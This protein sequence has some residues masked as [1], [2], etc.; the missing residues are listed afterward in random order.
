M[1]RKPY[2]I[3]RPVA[4]DDCRP[5]PH[6]SVAQWIEHQSSELRVAGSSP[7]GR[8]K[9]L[10]VSWENQLSHCSLFLFRAALAAPAPPLPAFRQFLPHFTPACTVNCPARST[11]FHRE[12]LSIAV[13]HTSG[14]ISSDAQLANSRPGSQRRQGTKRRLGTLC[15][16][17]T[18]RHFLPPSRS[19][20]VSLRFCTV[21]PRPISHSNQDQ[22]RV[23]PA[24]G[25]VAGSRKEFKVAHGQQ[26]GSTGLPTAAMATQ[27]AKQSAA[28]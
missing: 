19:R 18:S 24:N 16:S 3:P 23:D 20:R 4:I 21:L 9:Y 22:K 12:Q 5:F 2:L 7:A 11:F 27:P 28:E 6:A 17:K 15:R 13:T 25:S 26:E 8:A 10:T 14:G 1:A